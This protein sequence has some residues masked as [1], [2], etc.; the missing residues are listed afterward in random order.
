M[1]LTHQPPAH[2]ASRPGRHKVSGARFQVSG[3]AYQDATFWP[4][5]WFA[6]TLQFWHMQGFLV[7]CV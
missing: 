6:N 2:W 7:C 3:S 4:E 5:T 1:N